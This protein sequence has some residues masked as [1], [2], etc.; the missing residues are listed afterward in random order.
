MYRQLIKSSNINFQ[1][2]LKIWFH[3]WWPKMGNCLKLVLWKIFSAPF[4]DD[5][6]LEEGIKAYNLQYYV[7]ERGLA[8]KIS[9]KV[10]FK[11]RVVAD[12]RRENLW[13]RKCV[14][15]SRSWIVAA[16]LVTIFNLL[17]KMD[18]KNCPKRIVATVTNNAST[19][20]WPC[21]QFISVLILSIFPRL[22]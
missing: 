1:Y 8:N 16:L 4:F 7:R 13:Y 21:L 2:Q 6:M 10:S 14:I 3:F 9:E 18:L 20:I 22:Q 19:V 5:H 17:S 12:T 11:L 15:K